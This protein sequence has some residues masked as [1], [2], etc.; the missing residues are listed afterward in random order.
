MKYT[1]KY[2]V[3]PF[4]EETESELLQKNDRK[5]DKKLTDIITTNDPNTYSK[6][7]HTFKKNTY[8]QTDKKDD[9]KEKNFE[10]ELNNI[11]NIINDILENKKVND[12]NFYK[13]IFTQTRSSKE[14]KIKKTPTKK[15]TP[16]K[17]EKKVKRLNVSKESI[18]NTLNTGVSEILDPDKYNHLV[19]VI[20]DQIK[21]E[22][23][24]LLT[25]D[26]DSDELNQSNKKRLTQN[27]PSAPKKLQKTRES[28][29][30]N[31]I[32]TTKDIDTKWDHLT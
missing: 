31:R 12:D 32:S 15:K 14:K 21:D 26:T 28:L 16:A 11:T 9:K 4:E 3:V 8:K 25:D 29:F 1:K 17:K 30:N 20:K 19:D 22:Q 24:N 6:Y 27:Q 18:E 7:N 23:E 10:K 5:L 2:M 13:P